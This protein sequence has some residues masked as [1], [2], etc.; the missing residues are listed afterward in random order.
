MLASTWCRGRRAKR[1]EKKKKTKKRRA[2]RGVA[3]PTG[4]EVETSKKGFGA[5]KDE[6]E[7]PSVK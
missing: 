4:R 7:L 3:G 1:K 2:K 6:Y 5:L